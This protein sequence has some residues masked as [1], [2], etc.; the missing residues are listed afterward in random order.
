[1]VAI[2]K[3]NA[4]AKPA[5]RTILALAV[6][7]ALVGCGPSAPD[8][9]DP[10]AVQKYRQQLSA[11]LKEH[12]NGLFFAT[13]AR[14]EQDLASSLGTEM[15]ELLAHGPLQFRTLTVTHIRSPEDLQTGLWRV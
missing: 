12:V 8:A 5:I 13:T 14:D 2:I 4:T 9:D 1:M 6:F 10:Q 15:A 7:G 11:T 3:A